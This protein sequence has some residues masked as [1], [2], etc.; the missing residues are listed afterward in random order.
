MPFSW[1]RLAKSVSWRIKSEAAV[2]QKRLSHPKRC[3]RFWQRL[4]RHESW[5]FST[6][7]SPSFVGKR[8]AKQAYDLIIV[9]MPATGHAL[10]LTSLPTVL[11]KLFGDGPIF[12]T[13][14]LGQQFF[15]DSTLTQAVVV[16]LP[17]PLAVQESLELIAGLDRD[18]VS[19]G[20]TIVNQTIESPFFRRRADAPRR[21]N[22]W[23][24]IFRPAHSTSFN[25]VGKSDWS[26]S[27]ELVPS[28]NS[29]S[30]LCIW[31]CGARNCD[32]TG[33]S[34]KPAV[35]ES[36]LEKTHYRL[37]WSRR[38]W[39]DNRIGWPSG[40]PCQTRQ[41]S[42]NPDNRPLSEAR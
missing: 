10:G 27:R 1:P 34:V 23:Q 17:E 13:L 26:T 8:T 3:K 29:N 42:T 14:R 6:I 4:R 25:S 35:F 36:L 32:H 16:S 15:C 37:L 39:K 11:L 9:D 5:E 24:R 2:L 30:A 38:R 33:G 20:A 40:R 28:A 22:R 21:N 18:N 12:D 19:V 31:Q 41:E 7:C